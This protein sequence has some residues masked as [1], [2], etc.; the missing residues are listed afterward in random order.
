MK[1]DELPAPRRDAR[2][3]GLPVR[4]DVLTTHFAARVLEVEPDRAVLVL[5]AASEILLRRMREVHPSASM[6]ML[7]FEIGR[8][9]A[10]SREDLHTR[11]EAA[12]DLPLSP[13]ADWW[14]RAQ[15]A[16]AVTVLSRTLAAEARK[17]KP[18]IEIT[19][20]QPVALVREP[21]RLR[22]E[23]LRRWV[24]RARELS[25]LAQSERAPLHIVRCDPPGD[26]VQ[27]PVSLD[28]VRLSIPLE[29]VLDALR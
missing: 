18:V 23:L 24:E 8:D 27:T 7:G 29:G 1:S 13:E 5:K 12:V 21:D 3:P 10:K 25:A 2:L 17:Q 28:E 22:A 11:V 6:R 14:T 26:V 4:P 20:Q 16:A 15:L 9:G 19:A